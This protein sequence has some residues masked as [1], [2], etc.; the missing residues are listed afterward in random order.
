MMFGRVLKA[1][2]WIEHRQFVHENRVRPVQAQDVVTMSFDGW[3]DIGCPV[4]V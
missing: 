2:V 1:I 4:E 3:D